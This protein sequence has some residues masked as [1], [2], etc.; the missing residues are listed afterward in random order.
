[1][2]Y[3]KVQPYPHL[4]LRDLENYLRYHP[5]VLE[6]QTKPMVELEEGRIPPHAVAELCGTNRTQV[7]RWNLYGLTYYSADRVATHLGV[8]PLEIW[9]NFYDLDSAIDQEVP[10]HA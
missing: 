10:C 5:V 1:M 2:A 8:H 6:A 7:H 3:V 4:P 9:P